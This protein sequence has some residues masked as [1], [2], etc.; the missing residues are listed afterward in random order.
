MEDRGN[1]ICHAHNGVGPGER[2]TVNLEVEFSPNINIPRP[3]V[4]QAVNYDAQLECKIH[5]FPPP[6]IIWKKGNDTLEDKDNYK[7]S[8]FATQDEIT[9]STLKVRLIF[10]QSFLFSHSMFRSTLK[11]SGVGQGLFAPSHSYFHNGALF[12]P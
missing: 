10:T 4:P 9:T 3:R 1:Y 6:S 5:A 7:V 2:R 8:H 11:V 12:S